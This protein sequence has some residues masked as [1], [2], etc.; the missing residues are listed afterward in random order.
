[1]FSREKRPVVVTMF[2]EPVN[3]TR[4]RGGAVLVYVL[5]MVKFVTM[6]EPR[7]K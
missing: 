7:R 6:M 4:Q 5:A 2:S 1:M 3:S